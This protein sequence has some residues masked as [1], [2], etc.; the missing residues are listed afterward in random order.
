MH[1]FKCALSYSIDKYTGVALFPKVHFMPL[2]FYER[3]TFVPVFSNCKKFT[4]FHFRKRQ[5]A[6]LA[7]GVCFAGSRPEAAGAMS[8]R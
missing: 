1:F 3:P 4:D 7:F 8:R 5:K 6:K 2:R